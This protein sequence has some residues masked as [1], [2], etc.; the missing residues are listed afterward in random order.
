[1]NHAAELHFSDSFKL[2]EEVEIREPTG[3]ERSAFMRRKV[4]S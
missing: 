3:L 4:A 1:M 2:F